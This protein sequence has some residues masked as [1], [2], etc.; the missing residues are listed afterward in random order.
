MLNVVTSPCSTFADDP[1]TTN[2]NT[3]LCSIAISGT[4]GFCGSDIGGPLTTSSG[5]IGIASWHTTPCA[6]LPVRKFKIKSKITK[7]IFF[8][9][10]RMFTLAFH[11][12][13]HGLVQS[14]VFSQEE[15]N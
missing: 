5:L 3:N 11:G 9:T 14:L 12:T 10:S 15:I 2:T 13:E 8:S 4:G 6:V 1:R 7:I